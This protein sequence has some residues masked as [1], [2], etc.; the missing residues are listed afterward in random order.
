M[1]DHGFPA[2]CEADLGPAQTHAVVQS[3]F[4]RPGFQQD[5]VPDTTEDCLIGA[6]CSCP[7]RLNGYGAAPEPYDL[8][9]HHGKRDA[10]PRPVWKIGQRMTVAQV[11]MPG[12]KA[13]A[14]APETAASMV[15]STGTVARNVS[16][17]PSG[18]CVVSVS[19]RLDGTKDFLAYP[20]FHQ[21][22][23]YG[24]YRK[25]LLAFCRLYGLKAVEA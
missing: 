12:R 8:T 2:A 14:E 15:V 25:E 7:T 6:H 5:P 13:G 19:C 1:N 24:D 20:G 4:D 22:F 9:H 11:V 23:F 16:V 18:G 21:L 3:L 17:P 10:V